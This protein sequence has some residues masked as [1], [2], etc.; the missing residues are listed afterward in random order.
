MTENEKYAGD[1]IERYVYAV[2]KRL[3]LK[4]RED[5]KRELKSLIDDLLEERCPAG[6]PLPADVD[7]VLL[8]LGA[9]EKLAMRY[10]AQQ[11]YAIGPELFETY[12]FILPLVLA[13]VVF[14]LTIAQVMLSFMG[15]GLESSGSYW[16]FIGV[17]YTAL[18][19]AFAF[20]TGAF[21]I[22]EYLK[23]H[24][25]GVRAETPWYPN[26]LPKLP[27]VR[28]EIKKSDAL[29]SIV[30]TVVVLLLFNLAPQLMGVIV[31]R[32]SANILPLFDLATLK[33]VILWFNLCFALGIVR[34]VIQLLIGKYTVWLAGAVALLNV[35]SMAI[36]VPLFT[37]RRLWNGAL[38]LQMVEAGYPLSGDQLSYI[39]SNF[40]RLFLYVLIFAFMIDTIDVVVKTVRVLKNNGSL[41]AASS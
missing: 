35:A 39:W 40:P 27:E 11:S 13:C 38:A 36:V 23:R 32:P 7:G 5:I 41:P 28:R 17:L 20:T 33:T 12:R 30:F 24:K 6:D 15:Q 31:L 10:N 26:T 19:Q 14:G 29:A 8:H 18:L 4:T 1:I 3:P 21:M 37:E 16:G 2:V 9:P 34:E 22:A 25:H